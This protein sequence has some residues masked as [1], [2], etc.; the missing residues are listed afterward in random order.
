MSA[1]QALSYLRERGVTAELD[2]GDLVLSGADDLSA[3]T[4][5]RLRELKAEIVTLLQAEAVEAFLAAIQTIWPEAR[6]LTP[7]EQAEDAQFREQLIL[8]RE[9]NAKDYA[10]RNPWNRK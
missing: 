4:I 10:T 9:A 1:V 7:E 3:K 5:E 6:M 2:G 8:L